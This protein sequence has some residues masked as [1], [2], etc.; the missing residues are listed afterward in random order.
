MRVTII[1]DYVRI[2]AALSGEL[3]SVKGPEPRWYKLY[4]SDVNIRHQVAGHRSQ[5]DARLRPAACDM[6]KSIWYYGTFRPCQTAR[7][8]MGA[9]YLAEGSRLSGVQMAA[10]EM[11]GPFTRGDTEAFARRGRV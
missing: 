5:A 4:G 2:I 7:G 9:V 3:Q 6:S 1:S 10:K 11:S 8:G